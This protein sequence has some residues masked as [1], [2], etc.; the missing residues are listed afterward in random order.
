MLRILRLLFPA[1]FLLLGNQTGALLNFVVV[2][3]SILHYHMRNCYFEF[4]YLF[5]L[6]AIILA[7]A[8]YDFF[9]SLL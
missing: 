9:K 2:D 5:P 3:V 6:S 4:V 8:I 7:E 1:F